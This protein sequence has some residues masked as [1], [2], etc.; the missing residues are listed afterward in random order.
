MIDIKVSILIPTYNQPQY[1]VQ[2]VESALAQDYGN[3]EV[4][5]NDDSTNNETEKLL[6]IFTSDH[7]FTYYKT[8]V[9]IGRVANYRKLLYEYATGDW[10]VMLDGDDYYKQSNY[11]SK[12]VGIINQNPALVLVGAGH[13]IFY[14]KKNENVD[15]VLV[16]KD[17]VFDGKQIFTDNI[18][19]PQ[20][21][22]NIYKKSIAITLNF[23]SHPSNASDAEGLYRL[24]LH[25]DI[26]YLNIMPVVWR[27][28]GDNATFSKDIS[29]QLKELN[30]IDSVYDYSL[31]FLQKEVAQKWKENQYFGNSHHILEL[32]FNSK[33]LINVIKVC[34][35]FRKYWGVKS[36]LQVINRY[37]ITNSKELPLLQK[38]V[39]NF[40]KVTKKILKKSEV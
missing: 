15:A 14:E 40:L 36:V 32:A 13:T 29:K 19:I 2:A 26:A 10:V 16:E 27:V 28:H 6:A 8:A 18:A 39:Y 5:V 31:A 24:C 30:F 21:T 9:N 38:A 37:L 7:R 23:Y 3:V 35:F 33:K 22:T 34:Y 1:I 4:I 20:H 11:I 25:G 12:A 17:V